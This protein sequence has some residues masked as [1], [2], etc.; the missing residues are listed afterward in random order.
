MVRALDAGE[1]TLLTARA[2][3]GNLWLFGSASVPATGSYSRFSAT[4]SA[5]PPGHVGTPACTALRALHHLHAAS[6]CPAKLSAN[7]ALTATTWS[8]AL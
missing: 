5:Q 1:G 4:C 2:L 8:N 6:R 3:P 7:Q